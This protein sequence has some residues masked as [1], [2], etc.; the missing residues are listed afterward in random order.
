MPLRI[1][2]DRDLPVPIGVQIKGQIEYGIVSGELRPGEQLPSVRELAARME[3]AQVTVSHVYAALKREGLIGVRPG[4][5]TYVAAQGDSAASVE[6]WADLHRLAGDM[7]G[8]AL[9]RGF[10]PA[11]IN[12]VVAA[13]L[14]TGGARRPRVAI[15]G[16]FDRATDAYA[17]DVA[18]LL[19]DL[20]PEVASC[21]LEELRAGAKDAYV[22]ACAADLV[23]TIPNQVR[24]V[25]RLLGPAHPP[26][27]G[28]SFV[29]HPATVARLRALSGDL[30]LGLVST[31]AEFL[32]T[33]LQGV[34]ACARLSHA[35]SCTALSDAERLPV[36]LARAD[37][38]VYASGSEEVLARLPAGTPAIEY[39]HT[40]EPSAV[41][42]LRPLLARIGGASLPVDGKVRWS[43][44]STPA[45]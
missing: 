31:F 18:D 42:A 30:R 22:R 25:Q 13:R 12:R 10:S 41:E 6:E 1:A 24:E 5:G 19:A 16:L 33:M 11:E 32:P 45:R 29:A 43:T 26:V 15:V 35:P 8:Q 9:A 23:L 28:L 3:V 17:R 4:L 2:L 39:L 44:G 37:V 27:Q 36:V 7:I 14:A 34:A 38:V 21:T 40:P 20:S